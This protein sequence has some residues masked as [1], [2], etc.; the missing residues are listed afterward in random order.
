MTFQQ[1]RAQNR[2]GRIAL[3]LGTGFVLAALGAAG[4]AGLAW[5]LAPVRWEAR[6]RLCVPDGA[7]PAGLSGPGDLLRQP[8]L[9][10]AAVEQ[11]GPDAERMAAWVESHLAVQR[12]EAPGEVVVS[13]IGEVGHDPRALA[14]LLD[15][16]CRAPVQ[17]AGA[18]AERIA[19]RVDHLTVQRR[20]LERQIASCAAR[21]ESLPA[22]DEGGAGPDAQAPHA[23]AGAEAM[24][25]AVAAL[26]ARLEQAEGRIQ[27][28]AR[29][30]DAAAKEAASADRH[31]EL[32]A[33]DDPW[34]VQADAAAVALEAAVHEEKLRAA[35]PD[36]PSVL[37]WQDRAARARDHA[38]RLRVEALHHGRAS[39][40]ARE[41]DGR[42][43]GAAR[44]RSDLL[45][46]LEQARR[47]RADIERDLQ[48]ARQAQ[49]RAELDAQRRSLA[50]EV[51][52]LERSAAEVRGELEREQEKLRSARQAR[53]IEQA[54]VQAV[55]ADMR[56]R[57]WLVGAAAAGTFVLV[58]AAVIA[59]AAVRGRR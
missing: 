18:A 10:A 41:G 57:W 21:I 51:E 16:L 55:E 1:Q 30:I 50:D 15:A 25:A 27:K 20:E 14:G 23:N 38:R 48:E 34:V 24:R 45:A 19:A 29:A 32:L 58:F 33:A 49:R 4:A 8:G 53:V 31:H 54:Q 7:L 59:V 36:L 52:R 26:A 2:R 22:P 13:L 17:D 44:S 11:A 6:A 46:G 12:L 40:A 56:R 42:A 28:L 3:R 43:A 35:R 47:E 39:A 5:G 37:R 9:V